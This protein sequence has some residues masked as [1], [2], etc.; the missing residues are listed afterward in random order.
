MRLNRFQPLVRTILIGGA[1]A[2]TWSAAAGV[3]AGQPPGK[4]AGRQAHRKTTEAPVAA[5]G[6]LGQDLFLAIDHRDLPLVKTLLKRGAD[7]NSRNG[8]EFVP[9]YIAA[10]S[11]QTDV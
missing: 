11:H 6:R 7:P 9:L 4:P 3:S 8:L 2:M 10:A 1:A 5:K